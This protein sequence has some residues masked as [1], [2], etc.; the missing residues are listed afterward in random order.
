VLVPLA[1]WYV[2]RATAM[3]EMLLL[4]YRPTYSQV[5]DVQTAKLHQYRYKNSYIKQ[6]N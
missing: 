1:D 4:H 5:R 3:A 2:A 6:F